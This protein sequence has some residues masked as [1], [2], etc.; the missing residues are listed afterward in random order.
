[1]RVM[2]VCVVK[3]SSDY[4]P[5]IYSVYVVFAR[6]CEESPI[7]LQM[8]IQ[9][10]NNMLCLWQFFSSFAFFKQKVLQYP[11]CDC[12][13]LFVCKSLENGIGLDIM[14]GWKM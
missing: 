10:I 11:A 3:H 6:D 1:M 12:K 9:I 4:R 13:N 7:V 2:L 5:E 14:H 8:N